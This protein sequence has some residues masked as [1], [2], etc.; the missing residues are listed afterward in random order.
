MFLPIETQFERTA[1]RLLSRATDSLRAQRPL[2]DVDG[3]QL[4][5]VDGSSSPWWTA[6]A[7]PGGRAAAP[8]GGRQQRP[9][10]D[11]QQL[12]LVDGSSA[13]TLEQADC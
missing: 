8:P 4:P 13:G 6:A 5:L 3:Q 2:V 11:G 7:P 9:L 12:P 1:F 10:V